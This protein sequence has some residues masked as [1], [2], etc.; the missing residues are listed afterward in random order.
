MQQDVLHGR[1][2][3]GRETRG[4]AVRA[5]QSHSYSELMEESRVLDGDTL[6]RGR[7]RGALWSVS[8]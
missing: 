3:H 1:R 8:V 5:A 6:E 2:R 4:S 7:V